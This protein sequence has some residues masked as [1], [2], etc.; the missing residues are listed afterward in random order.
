MGGADE[1]QGAEYHTPGPTT[2]QSQEEHPVSMTREGRY[3]PPGTLCSGY[4]FPSTARI[5]KCRCLSVREGEA[6]P[7]EGAPRNREMYHLLV[8][9]RVLY[10][11]SILTT[12]VFDRKFMK[13][14]MPVHFT[15]GNHG[16]LPLEIMERIPT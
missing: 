16:Q 2:F 5:S 4:A 8:Q 15:S 6:H 14:Y 7:R 13:L 9:A 11:I 1:G 12:S 3:H 10:V